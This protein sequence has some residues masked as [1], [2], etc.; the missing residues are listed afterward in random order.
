MLFLVEQVFVGS[1][2]EGACTGFEPLPSAKISNAVHFSLSQ[3][4]KVNYLWL[5]IWHSKLLQSAE[6]KSIIISS[7]L[8]YMK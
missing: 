1:G 5:Q 8:K 6:K 2:G 4:F 7:E 3:N